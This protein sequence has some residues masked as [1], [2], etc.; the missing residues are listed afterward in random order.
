MARFDVVKLVEFGFRSDA[1]PLKEVID[2]VYVAAFE[3]VHEVCEAD[4][5][6]YY[7]P[8]HHL[9]RAALIHLA[10]DLPVTVLKGPLRIGYLWLDPGR[11]VDTVDEGLRVEI[12]F[13]ELL[14]QI[15]HI[16]G[17]AERV[18]VELCDLYNSFGV[19]GMPQELFQ[20]DL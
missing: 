10:L 1:F 4:R 13:L 16:F 17:T 18:F 12:V 15:T 2:P 11:E 20:T 8:Q 3:G 6:F 9:D 7:V 14:D 19:L 5:V